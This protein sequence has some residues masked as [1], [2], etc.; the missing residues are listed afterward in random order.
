MRGNVL[1]FVAKLNVHFGEPKFDVPDASKKQA[2]T[3]WTRA[4]KRNFEGFSDEVLTRAADDIIS[5][6]QYRSFP[7]ISECKKAVLDADKNLKA[8]RPR[9][10]TAGPTEGNQSDTHD[11][12]ERIAYELILGPMGQRAGREGWAYGLFL[13]IRDHM[14]LPSETAHCGDKRGLHQEHGPCTE[15]ECIKRGSAGVMTTLSNLY[16]N[17]FD[18]LPS[19]RADWEQQ[20]LGLIGIGETMIKRREALENYVKTG[21]LP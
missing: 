2:M 16:R 6:R 4:M 21:V 19:K 11:Y 9:L 20:R 5:T 14:R 17:E 18:I 12:R 7:L 8:E 1:E 3:E 10:A 13:F 15:I